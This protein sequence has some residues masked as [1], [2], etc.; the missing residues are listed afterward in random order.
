[1]Y[2]QGLLLNSDQGLAVPG[3]YIGAQHWENQVV[4]SHIF[5]SLLYLDTPEVRNHVQG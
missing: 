3:D 1:M 4:D 2:L 5:I